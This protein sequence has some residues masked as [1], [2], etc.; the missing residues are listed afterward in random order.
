MA[1]TIQMAIRVS[2]ELADLVDRFAADA[3]ATMRESFPGVTIGRVDAIRIL[4]SEGLEKR[5]YDVS[6]VLL[7]EERA[8]TGASGDN[9]DRRS[10]SESSG[11][12][13]ALAV[14][15]ATVEDDLRSGLFSQSEI[16]RRHGCSRQHVSQV[17]KKM[18]AAGDVGQRPAR[19]RRAGNGARG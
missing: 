10:D 8:A 18:E 17:K 7:A 6:A 15:G 16:A 1:R 13:A 19:N 5:G 4:L 11:R 14:D 9:D 3:M 2:P 12:N